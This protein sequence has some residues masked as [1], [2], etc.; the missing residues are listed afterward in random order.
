MLAGAVWHCAPLCAAEGVESAERSVPV[1]PAL[2][3]RVK[4]SLKWVP[5]WIPS[6]TSP[7]PPRP[8]SS[9]A[10][11]AALA[12]APATP[13]RSSRRY[14]LLPHNDPRSIGIIPAGAARPSPAAP[15]PSLSASRSLRP[16]GLGR[17]HDTLGAPPRP[18]DDHARSAVGD[19][20]QTLENRTPRPSPW[21]PARRRKRG[22]EQTKN[23]T[24]TFVSQQQ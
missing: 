15:T 14:T 19:K 18:T 4:L 10:I 21:A 24:R 16:R 6:L 12:A 11:R 20:G 3:L 8:S 13:C 2:H 5:H 9:L 17:Q 22:L 7:A 1:M 23:N